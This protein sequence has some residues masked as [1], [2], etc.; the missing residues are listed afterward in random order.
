MF[1]YV[2]YKC[3]YLYINNRLHL[4]YKLTRFQYSIEQTA[5]TKKKHFLKFKFKLYIRIRHSTITKSKRDL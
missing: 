3:R 4:F 2:N 1:Y 5:T